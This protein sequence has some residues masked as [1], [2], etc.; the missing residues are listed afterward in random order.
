MLCDL[1]EF[2]DCCDFN[3]E[4]GAFCGCDACECCE[5]CAHRPYCDGCGNFERPARMHR[6]DANPRVRE[7]QK[8]TPK[9]QEPPKKENGKVAIG[10]GAVAVFIV[11]AIISYFIKI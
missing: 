6:S 5:D 1:D 11:L 8:N 2:D 10:I 9:V 7:K 3:E 4:H